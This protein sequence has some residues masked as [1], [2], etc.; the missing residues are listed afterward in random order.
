MFLWSEMLICSTRGLPIEKKIIEGRL[1]Y[2][3][4]EQNHA[5]DKTTIIITFWWTVIRNGI[6]VEWEVNGG[7][8]DT[9]KGLFLHC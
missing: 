6:L 9:Q 7:S 5:E 8:E 2:K 1:F 4:F 3:G